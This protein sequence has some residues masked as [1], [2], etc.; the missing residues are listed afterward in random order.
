MIAVMARYRIILAA[1]VALAWIAASTVVAAQTLRNISYGSSRLDIHQPAAETDAAPILVYVHGGR[2]K[3]GSK[4]RVGAKA[5]YFTDQGYLFVSIDYTLYPAANA[6]RQAG[7]VGEAVGWLRANGQR[8]GGD[9]GAIAVL[10]HSAGCHL[11][12]LAAFSGRLGGIRALVC[13][14]TGAFDLHYLAQVNNG[15]LPWLYADPFSDKS[16]WTRFSPIT[17]ARSA[18]PF[19]TMVL[20]SGGANRPQISRRFAQALRSAGNK[21]TTFDGSAYTHLSIN[22][23][24]GRATDP[25]TRAVTRFLER[26]LR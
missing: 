6:W 24:M 2:W 13:N 10:G 9:P 17:Y 22:S 14:D 26:F 11:S 16:G 19:A 18:R 4:S 12:A 23:A 8:F 5:R 15:Q 25:A 1:V 3:G 7:Q 21:V 20:W